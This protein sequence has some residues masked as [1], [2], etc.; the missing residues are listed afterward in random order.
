M[1]RLLLPV[2]LLV[3]VAWGGPASPADVFRN[4][5]HEASVGVWWHWMGTQ[6]TEEGVRKDLAWFSRMGIGY[7]TISRR[8]PA[9]ASRGFSPCPY[10]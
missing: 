3:R 7:A 6:V 4:P 9:R 5:P 10:K 1:K 2:C 8:V